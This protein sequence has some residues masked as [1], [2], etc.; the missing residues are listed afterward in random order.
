MM[1][2]AF[3]SI[4][5]VIITVC[6]LLVGAA[7]VQVWLSKDR[8]AQ[9]EAITSR[10]YVSKQEKLGDG[11]EVWHW[12]NGAREWT[13]T[14]EVRRVAGAKA[15]NPHAKARREAAEARA[16]AD[17]LL[18]EIKALGR[19]QKVSPA[20]LKAVAEKHGKSKANPGKKEK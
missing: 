17:A 18:D 16:E 13:T 19:K 20:D 11:R 6:A 10:P 15:H 3:W 7:P 9:L 14:Q 8:R 5:F 12:R 1:K 2:L 4:L